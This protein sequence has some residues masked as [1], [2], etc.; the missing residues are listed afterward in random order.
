MRHIYLRI[1]LWAG[2]RLFG[3]VSVYAPG[4]A[5]QALH[6]AV[7]EAALRRSASELAEKVPGR[8][9]AKHVMVTP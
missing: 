2:K 7:D 8:Q 4:D 1:M 9:R 3:C 5:V 6:F